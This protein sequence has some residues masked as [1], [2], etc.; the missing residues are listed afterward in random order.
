MP[1]C[2]DDGGGNQCSLYL[3]AA[4]GLQLVFRL[5]MG[6]SSV[7]LSPGRGFIAARVGALSGGVGFLTGRARTTTSSTENDAKERRCYSRSTV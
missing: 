5:F 3:W 1:L 7:V 6:C 2:E 4:E